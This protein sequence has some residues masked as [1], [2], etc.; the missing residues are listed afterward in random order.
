MDDFTQAR[1]AFEATQDRYASFG[2]CDTEPRAVF[3]SLLYALTDGNDPQILTTAD[4]WDLFSDKPGAEEAAA[5]L[6][7]AAQ[8]AIDAAKRD[9]LA[10]IRYVRSAY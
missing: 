7:A 6:T 8:T 9:T 1:K 3:A 4:G 5:A 10:V 2:A